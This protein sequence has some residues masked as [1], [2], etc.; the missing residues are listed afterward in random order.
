MAAACVCIKVEGGTHGIGGGVGGCGTHVVSGGGVGA[1]GRYVLGVWGIVCVGMCVEG[2]VYMGDV[3]VGMCHVLYKYH[4]VFMCLPS[5][6]LHTGTNITRAAD[7]YTTAA[8]AGSIEAMCSLGWLYTQGYTQGSSSSSSGGGGNGYSGISGSSKAAGS[9]KASGDS[10]HHYNHHQQHIPRNTTLAKHWYRTALTSAPSMAHAAP[11][12]LGLVWVVVVECGEVLRGVAPDV[13]DV[14][15]G[16]VVAHVRW[17]WGWV[18]AEGEKGWV[19]RREVGLVDMVQQW[20]MHT[21]CNVICLCVRVW[22]LWVFCGC[23][24]PLVL[25]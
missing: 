1:G 16:A 24:T 13:W 19:G 18:A 17:V 6:Y 21:V 8:A 3:C 7:L 20:M 23:F 2:C 22:K 12:L 10:T 11:A 14:V 25:L 5:P 9:S 4:C 15:V